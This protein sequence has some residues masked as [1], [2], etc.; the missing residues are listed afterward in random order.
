MMIF[1]FKK[2][3]FLYI[4]F[5]FPLFSE[6]RETIQ[7]EWQEVKAASAYLLEIKDEKGNL[8]FSQKTKEKNLSVELNTGT[9]TKRLTVFNLYG[10]KEENS[11]WIPLIVKEKSGVKVKVEWQEIEVAKKYI[12][13]I[14]DSNGNIIKRKE[15]ESNSTNIRLEPGSYEK[16][17][18]VI[19]QFGE[20][21]SEGSWSPLNVILVLTPEIENTP[22]TIKSSPKKQRLTIHGKNFDKGMTASL[23][24]GNKEVAIQKLEIENREKIQIEILLEDDQEGVYSLKLKNERGKEAKAENY[25]TITQADVAEKTKEKVQSWEI[26]LRSSVV[27]GWGQ[28]YAGNKYDNSGRRI[29]GYV[30]SSVF[31]SALLYNIYLKNKSEQVDNEIKNYTSLG[32]AI[33][34]SEINSGRDGVASFFVVPALLERKAITEDIVERN[35]QMNFLMAGIY[36]IQIVD[37]YLI[38]KDVNEKLNGEGLQ[39]G[40]DKRKLLQGDDHLFLMNYNTRF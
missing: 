14:R 3:F 30:F 21:E 34:I 40:Y 10:E 25:L 4:L 28:I 27:P 7:I 16:R 39:V 36:L 32:L 23:Y 6:S 37:A 26:L 31:F 17:L 13:E 12:L 18:L 22:Q 33:G 8:V 9:Y 35:K 38:N 24:L 19:N 20:V 15:V 1:P 11:E 29:R 2:I 5:L